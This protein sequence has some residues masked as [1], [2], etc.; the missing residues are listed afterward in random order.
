MK[1]A[2]HIKIAVFSYEKDG[3]DEALIL[4]KLL[5][6]VPF[7]IEQEKIP[8]S[9]T[10]AQGFNEKKITILEITLEKERHTGEF[11][12]NLLKLLNEHQKANIIEQLESRLDGHLKFFLRFDKKECIE[13]D[14]LVLTDS[15]NCFHIEISIAAFPKKR[16]AAAN[17]I[18][19]VFS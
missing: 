12:E 18:R 9:K 16:E 19:R 3:E 17:I 15:G 11:L 4:R 2:H 5:R 10:E 1:I 14:N 7:D 13:N 6:L 8:L